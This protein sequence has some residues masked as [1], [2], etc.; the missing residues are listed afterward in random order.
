MKIEVSNV[1]QQEI[2]KTARYIKKKFGEK[3][4]DKFTEEV[5]HTMRLL[6]INPLM[7]PQEQSLDHIPIEY[8]SIVV[9]QKTR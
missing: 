3:S 9:A 2:R 8:H 6:A 1:A 4:R 7:G 5:N